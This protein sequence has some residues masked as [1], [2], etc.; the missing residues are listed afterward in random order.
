MNRSDPMPA[1]EAVRLAQRSVGQPDAIFAAIDKA[2]AG[3]VGH[4]LFTITLH[5]PALNE[6]ERF[7]SNM[8]QVYPVGGR[9]TAA[10]AKAMRQ[11]LDHGTPY[12]ARTREDV[13]GNFA[14]H[15]VI[16]SLGCESALN[17]PIV[18]NGRT[19]GSMNL[20]HTANWYGEADL[21][22]VGLFAALAVPGALMAVRQ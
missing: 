6:S 7:Y 8:P 4:T 9:K 11:I 15:A 17:M 19:L 16:L 18:W 1:L 13:I 2:L 12:I 5:H 3:C 20:L 21:P 22:L 10:D 14:D